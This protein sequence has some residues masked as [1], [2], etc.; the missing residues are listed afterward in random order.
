MI[1]FYF[2][3][4]TTQ[5]HRLIEISRSFAPLA[6]TAIFITCS[7]I[8]QVSLPIPWLHCIWLNAN[9]QKKYCQGI[10]CILLVWALVHSKLATS[11]LHVHWHLKPYLEHFISY[12]MQKICDQVWQNRSYC[13]CQQFWFLITNTKVY[14]YTIKFHI[15]HTVVCFSKIQWQSVQPLRDANAVLTS[16]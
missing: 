14:E 3:H 1:I 15:Y 10:L 5:L 12:I 9:L 16:L 4:V 7:S 13:P 8:T 6:L 11:W 2:L